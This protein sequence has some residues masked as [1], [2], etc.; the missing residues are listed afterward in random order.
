MA[1]KGDALKLLQEKVGVTPDG[2][3]GPNTARAITKH[4]GWSPERAA[5]LLGQG[6][7]ES[8]GFLLS[9]ENLNYS[10]ETMMRVWPK[11]FPTPA[12]AAPY[13][14]N[15]EALAN[16]T[17]GG[18]MGNGPE[19]SGD[20]WK[21]RGRG[22]IQLT[23]ADNYRAFAQDIGRDSLVDNPDEVATNLAMESAI[24]FFEKNGLFAIA[25]GG[26]SVEVIEKITKLVNGGTHGLA[27]RIEQ[28]KKIQG[29]LR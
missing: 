8:G 15:P 18:R 23:G 24:W 7:H 17:Y 1:K 5:H 10:A 13:A 22:F 20:G 14:R 11:R 25:D 28:T 19:G 27:D 12:A 16:K 4:Y 9:E 21:Y 2:S 26:V 6:A 29:W 3:F